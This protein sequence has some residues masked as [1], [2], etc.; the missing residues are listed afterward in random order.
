MTMNEQSH[1]KSQGALTGVRVV[2]IT[3]TVLGPVATQILGDLGADVVKIEPPDGDPMRHLGPSRH[4]G[5]AAMFLGMNRNKRSIVL[6]L[7][8]PESGEVLRRLVAKADVVVHNMRPNAA[9]RLSVSYAHLSAHNPRLVYASASGYRRDGPNRDLP[10]FDELIQSVSGISGLFMRG[11]ERARY[12]PFVIAD[13]VTGYVLASSISAALF[14]RERSGIGQE[15]QV[16]MFETL[17]EFNLL[18]HFWGRAFVPPLGE[19]GYPRILT[20][21]RRPFR[22]KDGFICVA[23]TTDQQ[24]ER[25]FGVVGRPDLAADPRFAKMAQ[26]T[27]HFE[28]AFHYLNEA[29]LARTT[30]EWIAAFKAVDLP[31]GLVNE[32]D[33]LFDSEYLRETGFFNEYD[34]P[35]EGRLVATNPAVSFSRTPS[36]MRRPPPRLGEHTREVMEKAG[37][38]DREISA[39]E[40]HQLTRPTQRGSE[41]THR[42]LQ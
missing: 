6:D 37:F 3:T 5:M 40:S 32:L 20:P 22:T 8:K 30:A 13:K 17:V 4:E 35:S 2:D 1:I 7:K 16:P 14:E 9:E 25:L 10:A 26:R 34:H 39:V 41:T 18:E 38:L 27:F 21:E 33:D 15:V 36:G 24:W 11:G 19:P 23:A 28:A 12:A 42:E 29:M 31:N